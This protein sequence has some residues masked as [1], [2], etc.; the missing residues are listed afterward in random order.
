M[1]SKLTNMNCNRRK[2]EEEG[3]GFRIH[4]TV[5]LCVS[6][7]LAVINLILI[8]EFLWFLFPLGGMGLGLMLHYF[9]GIKKASLRFW[10]RERLL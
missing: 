7:L 8:P 10:T 5:Y 4:T 1:D 3:K 9:L 2:E 6:A